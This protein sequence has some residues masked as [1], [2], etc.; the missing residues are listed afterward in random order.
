M[1]DPAERIINLA[2]FLA[3]TRTPVTAERIRL[4]VE[5]YGSDQDEAAFLRMFERDKDDL[6]AAG[7]VVDSTA[8]GR[9]L[10]DASR[11]F[12]SEVPLSAEDELALRAVGAALLDDP[13]FPFPAELRRAIHK[14]TGVVAPPA[15]VAV[16]V[17]D[18]EPDVQGATVAELASAS[19]RRKRVTYDYTNAA[20]ASRPHE[21]EPLGLFL[22]DGRWY[23]VGRDVSIDEVR[24]YA[25]SRMAALSVH[26]ARPKTP[27]FEVPDGF[28]VGSFIGLPFQYGATPAFEATIRFA[29]GRAWSA[30]ALTG[31]RGTLAEAPD[32]GLLWRITAR[33]ERAV[34]RWA[35]AHGPG[36]DIVAPARLVT[37]LAG[38]LERAEA[39]HA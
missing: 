1:P 9:Y 32:G 8:D 10:L 3:D 33:D 11:S 27:D 13:A 17:A 4:E 22:R 19:A 36:I 37:A 30:P 7:L 26:A 39:A 20:G 25:V 29:P 23:L 24:V 31:G 21:V 34:L 15:P 5:G 2:M 35:L 18:E 16:R 28:D 6:R 38:G 14:L 12:C